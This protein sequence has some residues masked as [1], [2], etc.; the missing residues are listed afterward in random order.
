MLEL[1][2]VTF[3]PVFSFGLAL[4]LLIGLLGL[5]AKMIGPVDD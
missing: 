5:I 1:F 2:L 4:V 3:I